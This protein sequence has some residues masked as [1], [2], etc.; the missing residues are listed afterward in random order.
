M[1]RILIDLGKK[2]LIWNQKGEDKYSICMDI[3]ID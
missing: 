1:F 2:N 3:V